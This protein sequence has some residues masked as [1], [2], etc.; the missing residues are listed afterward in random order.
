MA[1]GVVYDQEWSGLTWADAAVLTKFGG[2]VPHM[3]MAVTANILEGKGVNTAVMVSD[4]SGDRRVEA[5]LLFNFPD[6]DAVVYC[7]GDDTKWTL[8]E[9]GRAIAGDAVTARTLAAVREVDAASVVG[10]TNQ[11]GATHIQSIIY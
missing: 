10:V 6:V 1:A 9:A 8:P 11:Q 2:G 5:A 4:M 7:G 3:D